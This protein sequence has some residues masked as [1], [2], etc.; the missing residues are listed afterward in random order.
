MNWHNRNK[1]P[2]SLAN[3]IFITQCDRDI[4]ILQLLWESEHWI[5]KLGCGGGKSA[6]LMGI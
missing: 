1:H 4:H 2:K 6:G 3:G 5:W